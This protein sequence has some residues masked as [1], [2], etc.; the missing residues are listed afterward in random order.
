MKI[1]GRER[2]G[3]SRAGSHTHRP[4]Y[5]TVVNL[6]QIDFTMKKESLLK[7]NGKRKEIQD[8]EKKGE[9]IDGET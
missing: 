3:T 5:T 8:E 9:K 6:L 7:K 1:L 4:Q 2:E